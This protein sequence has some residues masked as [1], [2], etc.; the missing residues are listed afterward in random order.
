MIFSIFGTRQ[1]Y[2]YCRSSNNLTVL[3]RCPVLLVMLSPQV[4]CTSRRFTPYL[5]PIIIFYIRWRKEFTFINI[6]I[7]IFYQLLGKNTMEIAITDT[8]RYTVKK[9]KSTN[10]KL[11]DNVLN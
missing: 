8:P 5:L 6:V 10:I 4:T 11:V 1:I 3:S 7:C 2:K 9:F